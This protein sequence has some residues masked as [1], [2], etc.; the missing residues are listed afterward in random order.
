MI[1]FAVQEGGIRPLHALVVY[2]AFDSLSGNRSHLS[3]KHPITRDS[4][5]RPILGPGALVS[6]EDVQELTSDLTN[7]QSAVQWIEESVLAAG[8]SRTV[9]YTPARSVPM[10]FQPSSHLGEKMVA[11]QAVLPCPPLVWMTNGQSLFLYAVKDSERPARQSQLYQ[12]PF[13]NVWSQGCVCH[14]NAQVPTGADALKPSAWES[15]FFGSWFTHPNFKWK[16]RLMMGDA[17]QFWS[18]QLQRPSRAFPLSRLVQ[19]PCTV[20]DLMTLTAAQL[21]ERM[22]KAPGEF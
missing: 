4:A 13:F 14:G 22:P 10:F 21:R 1:H 2:E 3:T 12:A 7:G 16:D 17:V 5:G 18:K 8:P 20:E 11:G 15:F 6:M 9:W 19:V